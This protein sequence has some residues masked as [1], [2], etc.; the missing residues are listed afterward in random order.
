MH[1]KKNHINILNWF[2]DSD[3]EFEYSH[4]AVDYAS[5]DGYVDILNW[6]KKSGFEF[7]Y[8][9]AISWAS[10]NGHINILEW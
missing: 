4:L 5:S 1:Q 10:E 2:R 7:R 3:S 8:K 6:F 9:N